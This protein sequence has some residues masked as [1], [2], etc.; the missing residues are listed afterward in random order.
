ML[1]LVMQFGGICAGIVDEFAERWLFSKKMFSTHV[2]ESVVDVLC[3]IETEHEAK[4]KD[5]TE[6][7][8]KTF[9]FED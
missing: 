7:R 4:L 9:L 2:T 8:V 1:K 6:N 5:F 3:K